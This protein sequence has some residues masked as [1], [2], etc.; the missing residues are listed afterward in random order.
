M[1]KPKYLVVA[2]YV[3]WDMEVGGGQG[4]GDSQQLAIDYSTGKQGRGRVTHDT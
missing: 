1:N 2:E 4:E 3:K